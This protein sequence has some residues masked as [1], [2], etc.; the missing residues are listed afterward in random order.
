MRLFGIG[1]MTDNDRQSKKFVV[2][3]LVNEN[4][5]ISVVVIA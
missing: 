3:K 1:L 5:E 2:Q 4:F